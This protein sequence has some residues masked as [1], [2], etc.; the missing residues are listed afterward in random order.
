MYC[1]WKR[2]PVSTSAI[3]D[4]APV[5]DEWPDILRQP[6]IQEMSFRSFDLVSGPGLGSATTPQDFVERFEVGACATVGEVFGC[7]ESRHLLGNR[8]GDELI[9]AG[10]VFLAQSFDRFLEGAR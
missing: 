5:E 6:A 10:S 1:A 7:L 8:G 4:L 2:Q 9:D 3:S